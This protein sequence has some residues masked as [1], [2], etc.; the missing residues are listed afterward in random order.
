MIKKKDDAKKE[1]MRKEG[2]EYLRSKAMAD[3]AKK[4]ER[5]REV[6]KVDPSLVAEKQEEKM[7]KV[8]TSSDRQGEGLSME[9]EAVLARELLTEKEKLVMS[10]VLSNRRSRSRSNSR[11]GGESPL[12]RSFLES[13]VPP[14]ASSTS[15]LTGG[16][17]P[18]PG[19]ESPVAT[20]PLPLVA[21]ELVETSQQDFSAQKS[22]KQTQ[23]TAGETARETVSASNV[24]QKDDR[25]DLVQDDRADL[26]KNPQDNHSAA[27]QTDK[28]GLDGGRR[29]L[30]GKEDKPGGVLISEE[31]IKAKEKKE[32]SKEEPSKVEENNNNKDIYSKETR[33]GNAVV[34]VV[35]P[36]RQNSVKEAESTRASNGGKTLKEEKKIPD[37]NKEE[38]S[39]KSASNV[40]QKLKE[41]K[42]VPVVHKEEESKIVEEIRDSVKD[43]R[44]ILDRLSKKE[45]EEEKEEIL[46]KK[47]KKVEVE[48]EVKENIGKESVSLTD[49]VAEKSK[50]CPMLL[51]HQKKEEPLAEVKFSSLS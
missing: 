22:P 1:E 2:E 9:E 16:G 25:P 48:E 33:N 21:E 12:P 27:G 26:G 34:D 47:S 50:E 45:E 13:P 32:F 24:L 42:R 46:D 3:D 40:V 11:M 29:S 8:V 19:P 38:E 39:S 23:T 44:D 18:L 35:R 10:A 49:N 20:S 43:V 36:K 31:K 28:N 6:V 37:I 41:E 15:S 30:I 7:A 4:E 51:L 17:S 5:G 14:A